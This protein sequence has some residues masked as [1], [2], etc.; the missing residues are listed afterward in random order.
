MQ[1]FLR[2]STTKA[3][4]NVFSYFPA[5]RYAFKLCLNFTKSQTNMLIKV[6]LIKNILSENNMLQ[7]PE[8]STGIY[9]ICYLAVPQQTLGH[10]SKGQRHHTSVNHYGLYNFQP[11]WQECRSLNQLSTLWFGSTTYRLSCGDL[12]CTKNEVFY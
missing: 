5:R 4:L 2:S 6:M 9:F 3:G 11:E 1:N 7:V 12:H 8:I 10:L